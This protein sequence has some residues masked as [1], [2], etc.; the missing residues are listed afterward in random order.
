MLSLVPNAFLVF[1]GV[2]GEVVIGIAAH[3][4]FFVVLG[5]TMCVHTM[6]PI[7]QI[8]YC[9]VNVFLCLLLLV[10]IVYC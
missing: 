7:M 5:E 10:M 3:L 9:L 6:L 2:V 1:S 4:V 8:V